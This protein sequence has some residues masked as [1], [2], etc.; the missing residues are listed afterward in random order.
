MKRLLLLLLLPLAACTTPDSND[1]NQ[2]LLPLPQN[3]TSYQC[4][5]GNRIIVTYT[6]SDKAELLYRQEKIMMDITRSASGS[7]YAGEGFVWWIKGN[8]ANLFM[9]N[10]DK[11]KDNDTGKQIERCT[12]VLK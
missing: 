11:D 6:G 5:S 2:N 1:F 9:T 3:A 8:D 4:D 7:R 12:V 10:N